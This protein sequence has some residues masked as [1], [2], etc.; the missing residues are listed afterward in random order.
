MKGFTHFMSGLAIASLFP[1]SIQAA[2]D[3]NPF[4]FLFAGAAALIPDTLDFRLSR[5]FYQHHIEITPDPLSPDMTLLAQTLAEAIDRTKHTPCRIRLNTIRTGPDNWQQYHVRFDPS[6]RMVEVS[7]GPEVDTGATPIE[8]R[9]RRTKPP[10]AQAYFNKPIKLE[11]LASFAINIFDGPHIE[12][13]PNQDNTISIRFIPWHRCWTHS[14]I[15][16][17]ALA[18]LTGL[19]VAWP[20]APVIFAAHGS[21]LILDQLGYMGSNLL[22]PFTRKRSPGLKLSHATSAFWNFAA[23]WLSVVLLYGNLHSHTPDVPSLPPLGYLL[24]IGAAPLLIFRFLLGS[25]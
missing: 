12:C 9:S 23:V 6:H 5:Y 4:Y 15:T 2:L 7:L 8:P 20:A 25:D 14:L 1:A 13:I 16:G 10:T 21:H 17:M 11:Y 22:W 24:L 18:L 3:G 19:C